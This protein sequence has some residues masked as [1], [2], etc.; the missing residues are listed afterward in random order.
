MEAQ[1]NRMEDEAAK[2]TAL[3]FTI[4]PSYSG[5]TYLFYNTK[6]LCLREKNDY[7]NWG[8]PNLQSKN[9]FYLMAEKCLLNQ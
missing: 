9:G 1:A 4:F 2:K 7:Q 6:V 5:H 8:L 3:K